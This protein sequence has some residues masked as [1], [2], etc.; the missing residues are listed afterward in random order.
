LADALLYGSKKETNER[1][2]I[3]TTITLII[4]IFTLII[5]L[6]F[7]VF[8]KMKALV[9]GPKSLWHLSLYLV[10]GPSSFN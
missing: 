9:L 6:A 10:P 3:M 5:G 2:E 1:L 4:F 8:S 7:Y